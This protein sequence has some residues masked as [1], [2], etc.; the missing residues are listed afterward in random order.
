MTTKLEDDLRSLFEAQTSALRA[1]DPPPLDDQIVVRATELHDRRRPLA[2]AAALMLI[3]GGAALWWTIDTRRDATPAD[4]PGNGL[5]PTEPPLLRLDAPGWTPV[6]FTDTDPAPLGEGSTTFIVTGRGLL[7]PRVNVY[8]SDAGSM[9]ITDAEPD[10]ITIAG[11]PARLLV[12]G[13]QAQVHWAEPSGHILEAVGTDITVQDLIATAELVSVDDDGLPVA[14]GPLPAGLVAL[15]GRDAALARSFFE[16]QW[17]DDNGLELQASLY[18][19]G[20]P[21]YEERVDSIGGAI[22]ERTVEFQGADAHVARDDNMI[23]LDQLRGF[24]VLEITGGPQTSSDPDTGELMMA[25]AMF[26]SIDDFV[27]VADQIAQ[28][29]T[30]AW[31]ESLPADVV[32]R[33]EIADV[34]NELAVFPMPDGQAAPTVADDGFTQRRDGI[35][36]SIAVQTTCAWTTVLLDAVDRDDP[37]TA[38][39]AATVIHDVATWDELDTIDDAL[40]VPDE[41]RVFL[42]ATGRIRALD[43]A[44]ADLRQFDIEDEDARLDDLELDQAIADVQADEGVDLECGP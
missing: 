11:K 3:I 24:W 7:G 4:E 16:Y 15:T 17:I 33:R 30:A 44:L 6:Y 40:A 43:T 25:D 8:L 39:A 5:M 37:E 34:A 18:P 10:A 23:R 42:T 19:G 32:L 27:A 20:R 13:D 14:N 35:A 31:R 21:V 12:D 29:D 38:I 22:E 1:G 9:P 41:D 36:Q 28:V 2:I 26:D